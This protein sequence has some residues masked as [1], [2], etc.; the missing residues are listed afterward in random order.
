VTSQD[1]L[2]RAW[3]RHRAGKLPCPSATGPGR[4]PA[5]SG[6][7]RGCGRSRRGGRARPR[8]RRCRPPARLPRAYDAAGC[9]CARWSPGARSRG[10]ATRAPTR[11][12]P[13][14]S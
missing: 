8:S 4:A 7:P 14:G 9:W 6:R 11:P 12:A 10:C 1:P 5:P 3:N 2:P 13:P